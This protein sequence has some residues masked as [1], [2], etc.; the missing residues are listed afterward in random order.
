MKKVLT[1]IGLLS[2]SCAF[3]QGGPLVINN[4]TGYDFHTRVTAANLTTPG[5]YFYVTLDNPE[6]VIPSGS[7]VS[8]NSYNIPGTLWKVST[9]PSGGTPRLGSH[10]SLALGGVISVN[11]Q[12]V[13]SEF[14]FYQAGTPSSSGAVGDPSY[15]CNPVPGVYFTPQASVEWFTVSSGG[16]TYTYLQAL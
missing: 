4:Y 8:Y 12:W 1:I 16:T 14:Q 7:S 9:S 6:L 15:S 5:C 13:V 10:P 11:T 2:I 3:A